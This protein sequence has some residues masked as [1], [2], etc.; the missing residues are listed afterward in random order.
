LRP[1]E[2]RPFAIDDTLLGTSS[3]LEFILVPAADL[4]EMN[5]PTVMRV[6][7]QMMLRFPGLSPAGVARGVV[8]MQI[9]DTRDITP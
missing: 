1:Y 5:S 7:M 3:T 8:G 9:R 2:W 6:R 4:N